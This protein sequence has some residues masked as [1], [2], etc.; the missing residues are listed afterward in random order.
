MRSLT[1]IVNYLIGLDLNLLKKTLIF[2][3]P[4]WGSLLG[5]TEEHYFSN[6]V[7]LLK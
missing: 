6:H 1:N 4:I 3:R 2:L 5:V 7:A